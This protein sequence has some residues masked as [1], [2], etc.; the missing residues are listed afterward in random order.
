MR[1]KEV[2]LKVLSEVSGLYI[3]S[4]RPIIKQLSEVFEDEKDRTKLL[5]HEDE[6][7]ITSEHTL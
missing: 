4:F 3:H 5:L 2:T 7:L 6:Y 1:D